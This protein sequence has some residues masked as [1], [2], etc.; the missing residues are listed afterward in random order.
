[1]AEHWIQKAKI[2]KGALTSMA[3]AKGMSISEYCA[4][5]D[6]SPIAKKRC[7]LAKTFAKMRK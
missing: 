1:M 7:A 2:K 4:S 5:G 6:L 3:A